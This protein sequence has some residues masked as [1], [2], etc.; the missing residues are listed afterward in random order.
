[1]YNAPRC[2]LSRLLAACA[3]FC[4]FLSCTAF[5]KEN[6]EYTQIGRDINIGPT[7]EVGDVTCIGCSIHI[8]G[9]VAGE[10]T[11]VAGSIFIEGQGQVAGDVT[12]VA[13]N[14]RL[15]DE[16]RIAGE[17]TVVGGEI[18]RA[19]GAQVSGDVTSVGGHVWVPFILIS[20]FLFLGLL[21]ALVVWLVQHMRGPSVPAAAA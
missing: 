18:R 19:P 16:V 20:P 5:A 1:M 6:P 3:L 4:L 8:R 7:Q 17:A 13:G 14:L 11:T 15:E 21:V 9:Q 2:S 10:A 12:A